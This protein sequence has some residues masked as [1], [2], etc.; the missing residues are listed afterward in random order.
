MNMDRKD[1]IAA[2]TLGC[3]MGGLA[4]AIGLWRLRTGF[5]AWT[6]VDVL[7]RDA[8][9][10]VMFDL[11]FGALFTWGG[12]QGL[13]LAIAGER[14]PNIGHA[15][16]LSV[17]LL[18]LGSPFLYFG[19]AYPE[20]IQGSSSVTGLGA[21]VSRETS[22]SLGGVV[23]ILAGSTC[24]GIIPFVWRYYTKKGLLKKWRM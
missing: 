4:I 16:L 19:I 21:G 6:S 20:Q 11:F 5:S 8:R 9:G 18:V 15:C 23:F 10:N 22:P 24:L 14:L 1:R 3:L 12:L 7:S 13:I 17:F 2:V